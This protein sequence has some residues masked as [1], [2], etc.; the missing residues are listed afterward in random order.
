MDLDK[1]TELQFE[2]ADIM[3][4][5]VDFIAECEVDASENAK[6]SAKVTTLKNK[7]Q[8]AANLLLQDTSLIPDSYGFSALDSINDLV[9]IYETLN[10]DYLRDSLVR[11]WGCDVNEAFDRARLFT[12]QLDVQVYRR[13]LRDQIKERFDFIEPHI[14]ENLKPKFIRFKEAFQALL[15]VEQAQRG[16]GTHL[17]IV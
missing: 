10:G 15:V 2:I 4:C 14:A 8:D 16:A 1:R 5:L 6:I 17:K 9:Q 7:F 13:A 12:T 3:D 11:N